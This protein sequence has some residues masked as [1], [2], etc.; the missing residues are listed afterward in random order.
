[1]RKR[2]ALTSPSIKRE[3][4]DLKPWKVGA[5]HGGAHG[6]EDSGL[7]DKLVKRDTAARVY[8]CAAARIALRW[9]VEAIATSV[10]EAP[11]E[12]SWKLAVV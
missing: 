11:S 12:T 2:R 6:W 10:P 5:K 7:A 9:V 4:R 8:A 1:M 3:S